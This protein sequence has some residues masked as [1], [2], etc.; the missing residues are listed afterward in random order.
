MSEPEKQSTSS[1]IQPSLLGKMNEYQ[2]LRFLQNHGPTSRAAISRE[3]GISPPTVSKAVASLLELH[4]LEEEPQAVKKRGRPARKVTV[5]SQSSLV[6]GVVLDATLCQIVSA[7][8][9][10]TLT[11]S[12]IEFPTPT[13]YEDLCQLLSDHIQTIL[14]STTQTILGVGISLPGLIDYTTGVSVLSPNLPITNGKKLSFD[15]SARVNLKCA[16]LQE[17]HSLCL[18]ERTYGDASQLK[19]F[20]L[21]DASTGVGLGVVSAG[22]LLTGHCGFAGEIGHVTVDHQSHFRCG[23]GNYGCLE[24]VASDSAL[25]RMVSQ[26]I[27][28]GLTIE[29]LL[30]YSKDGRI[31]IDE[32]VSLVCHYLGIGLGMVIN[33]FNPATIY[34]YAQ[35]LQA[36]QD[37][38][39]Q[40]LEQTQRRAL[41]PSFDQCEIRLAN[42]TKPEGA[43]ATIIEEL[44]T[45]LVPN[46]DDFS[47]SFSD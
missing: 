43:I 31:D 18:A 33:L 20:A 44:S 29:E 28:E 2:I 7:G 5:A 41:Q 13:T 17:T 47:N 9:D 30:I 1:Q 42:G 25:V 35:F 10:G 11:G 38:F 14:G 23:C 36:R 8:F 21:L 4:Y 46:L 12:F 22:R 19:D 16:L 40:V 34:V 3:T 45:S 24:T 37:A 26:R 32:E 6:I 27:G 15:L 39:Q